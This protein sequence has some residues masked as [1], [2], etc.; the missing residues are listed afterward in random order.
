[1]AVGLHIAAFSRRITVTITAT[2]T[3]TTATFALRT[4]FGCSAGLAV[5]R[6]TD[7]LW[8]SA[9]CFLRSGLRQCGRARLETFTGGLRRACQPGRVGNCCCRFVAVGVLLAF[10]AGGPA[11]TAIT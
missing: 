8:F 5:Q 4:R 9:K 1:M 7:S 10:L 6:L 3:T 11:L 2:P